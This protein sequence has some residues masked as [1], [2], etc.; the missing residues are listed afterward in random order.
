MGELAAAV[1][2]VAVAAAAASGAGGASG[3]S[4]TIPV[5]IGEGN[6]ASCGGMPGVSDTFAAA[7]WVVSGRAKLPGCHRQHG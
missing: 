4:G 2:T 7:L 3:A 5:V 6:S 1:S